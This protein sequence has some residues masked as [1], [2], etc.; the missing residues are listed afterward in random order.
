M[1]IQEWMQNISR[2]IGELSQGQK[3]LATN[4]KEMKADIKST[5]VTLQ[6]NGNSKGSVIAVLASH[7]TALRIFGV[8]LCVITPAGIY[9]IVKLI[10]NT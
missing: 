5:K 2:D 8:A 6:G 4:Q 9:G 10:Q 7:G 3:D 1:D